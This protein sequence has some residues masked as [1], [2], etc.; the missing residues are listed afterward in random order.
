MR[1]FVAFVSF[2]LFPALTLTAT[3][4]YFQ[5]SDDAARKIAVELFKSLDDEQKNQ[6]LKAFDDKDRHAEVF[7]AAERKGLPFIKMKPEQVALVDKMI[8]AMT[9]NY[10]AGRCMEIAKQTPAN[11]RYIN[12][13]GEPQAG[14]PFAFRLAQHH[15]TLI[16]CEFNPD[17]MNEFGPVLLGGN[18]VNSLW[19]EEEAILLELAKKL[20]KEMLDKLKGPGGSGQAVGK[21]G[22][23]IKDLPKPAAELAK[24]LLEKRLDVFSADR[25]KKLEKIIANQGGVN[26]LKFILNGNAT[27]GHLQGGNY[28]WKFGNE[29]IL[30]DWQ[31][32]G[33]NHLHLTV[34]AKPK[35]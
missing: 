26:E 16:H 9:S 34:K 32:A 10:G 8:L 27:S 33:K 14:K 13:F 4:L 5:G 15:L 28:S 21:S 30:I 25:K 2:V 11:R 6:A 17:N 3:A 20:D 35:A 7:P 22:V 18:P 12:F 23:A 31:T 24:K 29:G 1:K 19:D